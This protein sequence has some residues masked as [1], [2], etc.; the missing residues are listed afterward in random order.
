MGIVCFEAVGFLSNTFD[1]IIHTICD[2]SGRGLA[3][4]SACIALYYR[5]TAVCTAY[6]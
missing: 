2:R 4:Q 3:K 5:H 6:I 1:L